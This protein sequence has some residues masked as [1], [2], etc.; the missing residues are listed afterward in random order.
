MSS[1]EQ[2]ITQRLGVMRPDSIRSKILM[3]AV[4]A[5]LLPSL[6]TAWISYAENK[7]SLTAKAS[8]ELLSASTQTAREL[9]LWIKE[10][11][12][13]LRVFASSYEVTE[14]LERIPRVAGQSVRSGRA[15]QRLSDYLKSVSERFADYE[16][17][18]ILDPKGHVVASSGEQLR[19]PVLPR[20]WL[21]QVRGGDLVI[22][23]PFWDRTT[24]HP[25]M[26]IA[27]PIAVAGDPFLGALTA[28]MNLRTVAETLKRFAPGDAGQVYLMTEDGSPIVSSR[29]SSAALMA[30]RYPTAAARSHL[31]RDEQPVEFTNVTGEQVVGSV[32]RVPGLNWIVVAEIPTVEVFLELARLRD[33]T[34]LIVTA[35]LAVAGALGYALGLFIVRPLDRLTRGAA[36]VAAGDLDVDL[37]VATG[38]EVGYLTKVFNN[39]VAHLR[40]SQRELERLSVTDHLTGLYNRRRM[41]EVLENEVRRSRR[42]KHTF[43]VLMGDVD[44]FK[45][46]NDANGHPAGDA[47]LKRVASILQEASRDVDFVARYGGEEFFVLMPETDAG[48]AADVAQRVRERLAKEPLQAGAVTLSFGVA[49]FPAHGDTGESVISAADAVLYQAKREGRDQVVVAA[50]SGPVRVAGR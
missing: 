3:F 7:R 28:K 32:R 25:E 48:G 13:D 11:R 31:A 24:N 10:R 46:Y 44:H 4:A 42:L 18:L 47:V 9:D 2:T 37:P 33:V 41:R 8:E 15:Y 23:A 45:K 38:G 17:L 49:E 16:E 19:A 29:E 50:F 43:A 14:N 22:G 35:M 6:T 12:Y 39:M 5:T 1:T 40:T 26:L 20:D 36:N 21:A 30:L 34:L 27:V